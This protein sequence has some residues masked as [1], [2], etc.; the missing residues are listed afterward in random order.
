MRILLCAAV[1]AAL[2]FQSLDVSAQGYGREYR[3]DVYSEPDTVD[4]EPA[5]RVQRRYVPAPRDWDQDSDRRDYGNRDRRRDE[6]RDRSRYDDRDRGD[7]DRAGDDD[8]RRGRGGRGEGRQG[9]EGR[10]GGGGGPTPLF[11]GTEASC[12]GAIV[13]PDP[14]YRG[15]ATRPIGSTAIQGPGATLYVA[16][17]TLA[18]SVTTVPGGRVLGQLFANGRQELYVGTQRGCNAGMVSTNPRHLNCA[19][20]AIGW[21]R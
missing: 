21:T 18:G 5:P 19:T 4:E 13:T 2:S 11:V 6:D 3:G 9:P 14:N 1:L 15:C 16:S 17:G 10:G 12:N 8:D 20:S 7:R